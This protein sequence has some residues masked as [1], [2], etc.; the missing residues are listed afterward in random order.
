MRRG[1][2]S[3]DGVARKRL[4]N[5]DLKEREPTAMW[6]GHILR[7]EPQVP[8]LCHGPI[9]GGAGPIG[10]PCDQMQKEVVSQGHGRLGEG[11][12]HVFNCMEKV[13]VHAL[14]DIFGRSLSGLGGES[15]EGRKLRD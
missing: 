4:L 8:G 10:G 13:E 9:E 12:G 6:R 1:V 11:L 7:E 5:R 14:V 15:A 2:A 3:G